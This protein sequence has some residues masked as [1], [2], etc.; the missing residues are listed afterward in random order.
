MSW[1]TPPLPELSAAE[2]KPRLMQIGHQLGA[3][4]A[5][6]HP[7]D[8]PSPE[9]TRLN[10]LNERLRKENLWI[11]QNAQLKYLSVGAP[12]VTDDS[13][14]LVLE[15]SKTALR[16][17]LAE[18]AEAVSDAGQ[19]HGQFVLEAHRQALEAE[20]ALRVQDLTLSPSDQLLVDNLLRGPQSRPGLYALR[21]TYQ[22]QDVEWAGAFVVT[23]ATT[24]VTTLDTDTQVGDVLLF[25]PRHGLESFTSLRQLDRNLRQRMEHPLSRKAFL[26]LLPRSYQGLDSDGIWPLELAPISD[27]PLFEHTEAALRHKQSL[28]I[29]FAFAQPSTEQIMSELD[30]AVR[31]AELDLTSRLQARAQRL[32]ER[33]VRLSA[34]DWYRSASEAQRETVAQRIQAY[35]QASMEVLTVMGPALSPQALAIVQLTQRLEADLDIDNLN[36]DEVQVSTDR[37]IPNAGVYSQTLS[38]PELALQG[39]LK[40]DELE[41]SDFLTR[42]HI[43]YAGQPLPEAYEDLTPA[44]LAEMLPALQ[45]RIDFAPLQIQ[46][47]ASQTVQSATAALLDARLMLLAYTAR[48]QNHLTEADYQLFE[49]LRSGAD[50][51]LTA[52]S[53]L[54]NASPLKDIWV[55]RHTN[56]QG[57]TVRV[58][59]CT[60][61]APRAEQFLAFDSERDCQAHIL[62]WSLD[63][64]A[65]PDTPSMHRYLLDQLLTRVRPE[66]NEML[67]ALSFKP[68]VQE[69]RKVTFTPPASHAD[70]L[71]QMAVAQLAMQ[72]DEY[73]HRTPDWLRSA[74]AAD[75]QALTT[76][77]CHAIGAEQTYTQ[78][79]GSVAQLQPFDDYVHERATP[80][81]NRL[82][83]NPTP[84]VDP[85]HIGVVTRDATFSLT[86]L[87]R[88]GY[89]KNFD[90]FLP[91]ID[92]ITRFKGP[93]GVDLSRLTPQ[94]VIEPLADS[95]FAD[96]Y[97]TL[98]ESRLFNVHDQ[99]YGLRRNGALVL[100]QLRMK[101]AAQA[102]RMQGVLA[103]SDQAW[104]E[105]S[106]D[107]MD[108]NDPQVRLNYRIYGLHIFGTL[109]HGCFVFQHQQ[110][111]PLLYTPGAPDGVDF[112]LAKEFN[113]RLKNLDAMEYY[114]T[115]RVVPSE[116]GWFAPKLA[117]YKSAMGPQLRGV[118]SKPLFDEIT[119]TTA[120]LSDLRFQF[121]DQSVNHVIA[122]VKHTTT[123]QAQR[124]LKL[125]EFMAELILSVATSPFPVLSLVVGSVLA[126][127]DA[128]VAL[129]HYNRGDS[130]AALGAYIGAVLNLGG[131]FLTDLRPVLAS[132]GKTGKAVSQA[133]KPLFKIASTGGKDQTRSIVEQ[134][135]P[136]PSVFDNLQPV[137]Y[138]GRSLWAPITA[139]SLGRH[140]L[141]RHD[142][143]SGKMLSTG[144]LAQRNR[145][146]QWVR[147]G[148]A[149]GA[150]QPPTTSLSKYEWPYEARNDI[151]MGADSRYTPPEQDY[152]GYSD[153]QIHRMTS[154]HVAKYNSL[155]QALSQDA[156]AFFKDLPPLV[157]RVETP[158]PPPNLTA[159]QILRRG[160]DE[161]PETDG[162]VVGHAEGALAGIKYLID[163]M[164]E[165]QKLDVRTLYI[166][167]LLKDLHGE[168]LKSFLSKKK[169][170]SS[171]VKDFLHTLDRRNAIPKG[172]YTYRKLLKAAHAHKIRLH[173]IGVSSGYDFERGL[174]YVLADEVK[175]LPNR[176]QMKVFFAHKA[177]EADRAS[178]PGGRWVALVDQRAMNSHGGV[179]GIADLQKSA[180]IRIEDVGLDAPTGIWPDSPGAIPLDP[181]AKADFKLSLATNHKAA[182]QPGPAPRPA[183]PEA[184][185]HFSD[186]D[187]SPQFR[188]FYT[189]HAL[190]PKTSKS[191]FSGIY[192]EPNQG[193]ALTAFQHTR[194]RLAQAADTFFTDYAPPPRVALPAVDD[195]PLPKAFIDR[196]YDSGIRGLVIAEEHRATASKALLI[197]HMKYLA[198]E[199][200]VKTLYLELLTSDLHQADLDALHRSR[201]FSDNLKAYLRGQD[202]GHQV[203]PAS[204]YNYTNLVQTAAK[205]GI[206]VRAIDCLASLRLDNASNLSRTRLMNYF[207]HQT[208][209]AD[210]AANGPHPWVAL[211]GSSHANRF[212]G[213]PGL[214]EMNNAV[215]LEVRNVAAGQGRAV[216]PGPRYVGEIGV[217]DRASVK[218]DFRLDVDTP[219]KRPPAA[220]RPY[221]RSKL[222]S[223]GHYTIE[224]VSDSDIHLLHHSKNGDIVETP[225]QADDN[226]LF[227]IDRWELASRRFY[228]IKEIEFALATLVAGMRWVP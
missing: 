175:N 113:E 227:F 185:A 27:K 82:L 169:W 143:A 25:T 193:Q 198:R 95:S 73:K 87:Y 195:T 121:Y 210:Q 5:Q 136:P 16:N 97:I 10:A 61:Q 218:I 183:V 170:S 9:L 196:V 187:L 85:D 21:F 144:I 150:P 81:L 32:L 96:D 118:Y 90:F 166:D 12:T 71:K 197:D 109:I 80:I 94:N 127:K 83:G 100:N 134:L 156:D 164:G 114:Y 202:L 23:T 147:T 105:R 152:L 89:D 93:P 37:I 49:A 126:F 151:R 20:A 222:A 120:P 153:A 225:I 200:E 208:I 1:L 138:G 160:F 142:A 148:V 57:A 168:K 104:L 161:A 205:Y 176:H 133:H 53:V 179:P 129:Y 212:Q 8:T 36:P 162:L 38:L 224:Q 145:T 180:S 75:R 11:F 106:I 119:R 35:N 211:V 54:L 214:A 158:A 140:L 26:S 220:M 116:R 139:D 29:D 30:D 177:I 174:G 154:P 103:S 165:L 99:H 132:I 91:G 189:L 199:K 123:S 64:H 201:I 60:P 206:R 173:P 55:L 102:A 46:A 77:T 78:S 66:W 3:I 141:L 52:S 40:G 155:C 24:A 192:K 213:N 68:E 101:Q 157:P 15:R 48:L 70:T 167:F 67:N 65:D 178:N 18:A 98:V 226:G 188:E 14:P 28:D 51:S 221:D 172:A 223:P 74:S 72:A 2:L 217:G 209:A 6:A 190:E 79:P 122:E 149:G 69:Y 131:A 44:Y 137:Q 42:S 186:F 56:P 76:Y 108:S 107:A 159:E 59:L 92:Y 110:N 207:A 215:A 17:Y 63:K 86:T 125:V 43:T 4:D 34:P 146:G 203:D 184:D 130:A 33:L 171:T 39:L 124:N 219:G 22:G 204:R 163:N 58:L 50:A 135:D 112:R 47:L 216:H 13:R 194:E 182:P 117:E 19:A 181:Q 41:G 111:P 115:H 62:G 88:N 128:M 191:F 228:S 7:L 84:A 45:P 31:C